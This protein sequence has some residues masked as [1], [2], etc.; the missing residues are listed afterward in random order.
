MLKVPMYYIKDCRLVLQNSCFGSFSNVLVKDLKS[1]LFFQSSYKLQAYGLFKNGFL[2]M[3]FLRILLKFS[4]TLPNVGK[5]PNDC[6]CKK[7]RP[8]QSKIEHRVISI[9]PISL[10]LFTQ[11][12]PFCSFKD[13]QIYKRLQ[14]MT[15]ELRYY[16]QGLIFKIL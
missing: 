3:Y 9:S 12:C 10:C 2:R 1:S 13:I 15:V 16:Q 14:L 4:V 11:V 5:T 8:V 6:L 7:Q